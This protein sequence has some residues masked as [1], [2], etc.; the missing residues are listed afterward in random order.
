MGHWS[1]AGCCPRV[2]EACELGSVICV[3]RARA[4]ASGKPEE[5]VVVLR[6]LASSA[7][8]GLALPLEHALERWP[9]RCWGTTLEPRRR[10]RARAGTTVDARVC[11]VDR[12]LE[13]MANAKTG[14]ESDSKAFSLLRFSSFSLAPRRQEAVAGASA[15]PVVGTRRLTRRSRTRVAVGLAGPHAPHTA[16][17][18]ARQPRT[19]STLGMDLCRAHTGHR[20]GPWAAP[21]APLTIR[22]S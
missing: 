12:N 16:P 10:R 13:V 14:R 17:P 9:L 1:D 7:S 18:P 8:A 11:D 5:S 15:L 19:Y 21:A 3:R 22:P 2:G 20:Q 6:G 4:D